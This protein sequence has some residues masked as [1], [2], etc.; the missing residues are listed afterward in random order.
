MLSSPNRLLCISSNRSCCWPHAATHVFDIGGNVIEFVNEWSHFGHASGDNIHDIE[1]RKSSLIG[2]INGIL[3]D[4]TNVTCS[5]KIRIIKT[6]CTSLYG[7]ELWDL[8]ND[9]ILIKSASPDGEV[10]RRC[11]VC[12]TQFTCR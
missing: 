10:S 4:F 2:Q 1:S 7:A 5:T 12:Q 11:G 9:Y 8:S 3:C 6:Y